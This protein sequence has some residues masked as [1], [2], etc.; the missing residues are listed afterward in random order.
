MVKVVDSQ[1]N[2]VLPCSLMGYMEQNL[3][4]ALIWLSVQ[5]INLK[6]IYIFFMILHVIYTSNHQYTL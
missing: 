1:N 5:S 6:F 4:L 3:L 2:N